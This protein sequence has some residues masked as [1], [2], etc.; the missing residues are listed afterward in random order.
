M[1][2]RYTAFLLLAVSLSAATAPRA[3]YLGGT[4]KSI[5][6]NTSGALDLTDATDLQ[7]Q[8]GT[9]AYRL[10]YEHIRNIGFSE[11]SAPRRSIAHVP[12]PHRKT[13]VGHRTLDLSFRDSGG[14]LGTMSFRLSGA[15]VSS[16]EWLL[17]ERMSAQQKPAE[18]ANRTKLPESW[19]G[20]R[21]WKTN[22]NKAIWPDPA[23]A[24]VSLGDGT[25]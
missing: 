18:S 9:L 16:L 4:V 25:K 10:P 19:W 2:I 13:G 23:A 24:P 1:P 22:R 5:P 21:Y 11:P 20:D 15:E 8:F 12:L 6:L 14:R 17:S 3:E 7:F